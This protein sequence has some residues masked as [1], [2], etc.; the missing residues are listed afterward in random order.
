VE[1]IK[2]DGYFVATCYDGKTVFEMLREREIEYEETFV[3]R[4]E[5]KKI[6][7]ITRMY[8]ETGFADNETSIGYPIEIY[9][10]SI[11]NTIR[12]YLVNANYF[13]Q[14]MEQYGFILCP[15]DDLIKMKWIGGGAGAA[16]GM[17]SEL[18]AIMET[19]NKTNPIMVNAEYKTAIH[20]SPEEKMVSFLNRYYIFK[21]VR[22]VSPLD[23]YKSSV[24]QIKHTNTP[25]T[26]T[27]KPVLK[28]IPNVKKFTIEAKKADFIIDV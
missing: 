13:I 20:L 5:N 2:K 18:F 14:L 22:D 4:K 9:Q 17:F 27:D 26:I 28:R 25:L 24:S 12:E 3:L 19:M 15:N 8:K 16:T 21:K 11:N 1:T 10:E 6:F 7:E 23:I